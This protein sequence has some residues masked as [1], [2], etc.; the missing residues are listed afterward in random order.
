VIPLAEAFKR[1]SEVHG[2]DVE[3]TGPIDHVWPLLK[4][5]GRRERRGRGGLSRFL[6]WR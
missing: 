2:L 4:Q 6:K 1:Y 5:D 3:T